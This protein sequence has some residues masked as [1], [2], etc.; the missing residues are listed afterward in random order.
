MADYDELVPL[1]RTLSAGHPPLFPSPTLV[2][3]VIQLADSNTLGS[4]ATE[5]PLSVSVSHV[6]PRTPSLRSRA[7]AAGCIVPRSPRL[8][9]HH[10]NHSTNSMASN[11]AQ[12][13]LNDTAQRD[14][15]RRG[16]QHDQPFA[17]PVVPV[18]RE[19]FHC[20]PAMTALLSALD[21]T[22]SFAEIRNSLDIPFG[23]VRAVSGFSC[24]CV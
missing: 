8:P 14:T 16:P 4:P 9:P 12:S 6:H 11:N 13:D 19:G 24:A 10:H 17:T 3:G 18:F 5:S 1:L 20:A 7:V 22:K 23:E 15:H 21:P 2:P